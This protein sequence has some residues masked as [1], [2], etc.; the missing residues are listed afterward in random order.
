[1]VAGRKP[2][3]TRLKV[4]EGNPGKRPITPGLELPPGAPAEPSWTKVLPGKGSASLRREAQAAWRRVVPDLDRFG[5]LA[6]VDRDILVAYCTAW[7][8]QSEA[9]KAVSRDGHIITQTITRKDGS[10][11]EQV[12]RHPALVTLAETRTELNRL[13]P[14]LGL[15]P[16]SR[17]RLN[18]A[19]P[20]GADADEAAAFGS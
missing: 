18:L 10:T 5:L 13:R 1:M 15:G 12:L 3:P 7:A 4:L 2:K 9:L 20:E 16:S 14:E 19:A 11:Y 6:H 8:L 17:S